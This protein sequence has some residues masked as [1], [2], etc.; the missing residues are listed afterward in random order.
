MA[1]TGQSSSRVGLLSLP[2]EILFQIFADFRGSDFYGPV[3][4]NK[5][6]YN[7]FTSEMYRHLRLYLPLCPSN[8]ENLDL[9]SKIVENEQSSDVWGT[10]DDCI[11]DLF[12]NFS[13][14]SEQTDVCESTRAQGTFRKGSGALLK[15]TFKENACLARFVRMLTI[16]GHDLKPEDIA[17]TADGITILPSPPD[18]ALRGVRNLLRHLTDL[19]SL[20]FRGDSSQL[21]A[22]I[23]SIP[24]TISSLC[25]EQM[26]RLQFGDLYCFHNLRRLTIR[27]KSPNDLLNT[28]LSKSSFW[29]CFY[30]IRMLLEQN[31]QTLEQLVFGNL[32]LAMLFESYMPLLP[33]LRCLAVEFD[34]PSTLVPS[35]DLVRGGELDPHISQLSNWSWLPDFVC[36]SRTTLKIFILVRPGLAQAENVV[37]ESHFALIKSL[38]WKALN[39]LGH[40]RRLKRKSIFKGHSMSSFMDWSTEKPSESSTLME[41]T[42]RRH[43]SRH[44]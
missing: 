8:V 36:T 1:P 33:R 28:K 29:E 15:R 27:S 17:T 21:S 37:D 18:G 42:I 26:S 38:D 24:K 4:V 23:E 6:L 40:G 22:I 30:S 32:N 35:G 20:T 14:D 2:N 25:L 3:L 39:K 19:E 7:L 12:E 31:A 43:R 16:I 41:L 9:N 5:L 11:L 44:S 13:I 10:D 34:P